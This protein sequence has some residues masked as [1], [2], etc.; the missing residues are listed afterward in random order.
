M[1]KQKYGVVRKPVKA[2]IRKRK[3]FA[4]NIECPNCGAGTHIGTAGEVYKGAIP[5][6]IRDL[7]ICDN[8]PQCDSYVVVNRKRGQYGVPANKKV[9]LLRMTAHH[10]QNMIVAQ[11]VLSRDEL[12]ERMRRMNGIRASKAHFCYLGEAECSRVIK[13]YLRLLQQDSVSLPDQAA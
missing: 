1:N 4:P 7:L 8:Y 3:G 9:R 12:Y 2:K 6:R 13:D 10:L 5:G 11:G